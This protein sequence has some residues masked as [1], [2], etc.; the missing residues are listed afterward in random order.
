MNIR[1][2]TRD[3]PAVSERPKPTVL[4]RL[5]RLLVEILSSPKGYQGGWEGGGRGL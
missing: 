1:W 3:L 4:H 5:I 2:N